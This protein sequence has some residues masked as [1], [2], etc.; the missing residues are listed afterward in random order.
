MSP[1]CAVVCVMLFHSWNV[2]PNFTWVF[3]VLIKGHVMSVCSENVRTFVDVWCNT[4]L[5][6]LT[7]LVVMRVEC[8][9]DSKE[10]LRHGN[11]C[12]H[13]HKVAECSLPH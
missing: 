1:L 8:C 12:R 7:L 10:G 5:E 3:H 11:R 2:T 9:L 4:G 13:T 6:K